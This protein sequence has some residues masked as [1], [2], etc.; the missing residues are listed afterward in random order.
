[1]ITLG[2]KTVSGRRDRGSS[3][4]LTARPGLRHGSASSVPQQCKRTPSWSEHSEKSV[5]LL[6][7][8]WRC[9]TNDLLGGILSFT[10]RSMSL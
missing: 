10:V 3:L 1:V 7:C 9:G 6:G 8:D 5:A 4:R 2:R